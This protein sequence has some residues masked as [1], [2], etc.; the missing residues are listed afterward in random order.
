MSDNHFF[1]EQELCNSRMNDRVVEK[2]RR[3]AEPK[4]WRQAPLARQ[5]R[6]VS[7]RGV[8]SRVQLEIARDPTEPSVENSELL[9]GLST[10]VGGAVEVHTALALHVFMLSSSHVRRSDVRCLQALSSRTSLMEA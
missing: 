7:H 3:L 6:L 1:A 9:V 4:H 10:E 5:E 2:R 8:L